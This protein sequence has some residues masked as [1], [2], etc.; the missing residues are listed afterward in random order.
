[1][2][3][4]CK[5]SNAYKIYIKAQ[6][7]TSREGVCLLFLVNLESFGAYERIIQFCCIDFLVSQII[8]QLKFMSTDSRCFVY[9]LSSSVGNEQRQEVNYEVRSSIQ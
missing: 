2:P 5:H 9:D 4:H 3:F 1:M 8:G 6:P 7:H